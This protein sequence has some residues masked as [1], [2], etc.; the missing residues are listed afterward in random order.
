MPDDPTCYGTERAVNK[1]R[2]QE[3][4]SDLGDIFI[5]VRIVG[6]YIIHRPSQVEAAPQSC[7]S[8]SSSST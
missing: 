1:L 2:R 6:C 8:P 5:N 4:K 3:P 7:V